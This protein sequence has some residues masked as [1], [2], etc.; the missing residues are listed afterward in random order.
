MFYLFLL[1]GKVLLELKFEHVLS[2]DQDN[3]VSHRLA[4]R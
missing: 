3:G 1:Q 2:A 4:V